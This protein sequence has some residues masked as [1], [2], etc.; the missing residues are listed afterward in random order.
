[1]HMEAGCPGT[2]GTGTADLKP[3]QPEHPRAHPTCNPAMSPPRQKN[4]VS[5]PAP[6]P[7]THHIEL[8]EQW[9]IYQVNNE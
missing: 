3:K 9:K 5:T 6:T 4:S 7:N 8:E 1:M 2:W